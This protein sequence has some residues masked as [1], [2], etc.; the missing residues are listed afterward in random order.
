L[1]CLAKIAEYISA[2]MTPIARNIDTFV[3]RRKSEDTSP[4]GM[5]TGI[6]LGIR[7]KVDGIDNC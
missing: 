6:N 7:R 5:L 3:G 2:R 4:M 1:G